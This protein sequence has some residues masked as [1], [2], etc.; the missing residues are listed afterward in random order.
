MRRG[1]SCNVYHEPNGGP[2]TKQRWDSGYRAQQPFV[3]SEDAGCFLV[4]RQA[5]GQGPG[6]GRSHPSH[7]GEDT[8]LFFV[9]FEKCRDGRKREYLYG[10]FQSV[11]EVFTLAEEPSPIWYE[12]GP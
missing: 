9:K 8:G 4:Q 10:P 2:R 11:E 6:P 1:P 12:H 7:G 5:E 3:P